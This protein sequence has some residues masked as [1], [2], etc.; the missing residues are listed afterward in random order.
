[1]QTARRVVLDL[2][3]KPLLKDSSIKWGVYSQALQ[4]LE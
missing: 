4:A 2:G 3:N 1:M